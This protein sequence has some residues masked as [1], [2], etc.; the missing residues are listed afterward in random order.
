VAVPT[1][2]QVAL[3][4]AQDP[5]TQALKPLGFKKSGNYYNRGTADGLVQVVGFQSGQ[6]VSI[7][8]GNFT[9]NLGV[10]V[11]CIAELEGSHARGRYVTDAHCEIR[12]RLREVAK[13]GEDQWWPLDD[14]ASRR[15]NL[16]ANALLSHGLP[17]LDR[18]NSFESVIG[19]YQEDGSLPS[20]N[21]ARSTLA[22]AIIHWARGATQPARE[23]FE[24]AR[25]TPSHNIRFPDYVTSLQAR[26]GL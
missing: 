21:P 6:A 4:A 11:P 12:S 10:Y 25:M 17:F 8:H 26:C 13:L 1:R 2:W 3:R 15:G 14:T 18:Y 24:R 9:V 22:I 5:V 16:V 19:Q 23:F 7:L 20:H